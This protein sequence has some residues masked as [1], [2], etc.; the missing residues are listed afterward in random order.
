MLFVQGEIS[1]I[2]PG[3]RIYYL[4]ISVVLDQQGISKGYGFVRIHS[5]EEYRDALIHMSGY[6][7]LGSR[8]LKVSH[9]IPKGYT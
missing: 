6:S 1:F 4:L 2:Y 9:A 8:P 5:E 3:P 7:G